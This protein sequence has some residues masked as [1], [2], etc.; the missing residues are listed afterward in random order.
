MPSLADVQRACPS[1]TDTEAQL[2]VD[3][4][5]DLSPYRLPSVLAN[6]SMDPIES[7]SCISALRINVCLKGLVPCVRFCDLEINEFRL[8][9]L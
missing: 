7:L 9:G 8:D 6:A 3:G 1:L 5:W 4:N 2:L